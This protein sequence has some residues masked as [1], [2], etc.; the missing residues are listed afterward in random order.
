MEL[1]NS[2]ET[3]YTI[4]LPES[5]ASRCTGIALEMSVIVP[6]T[7]IFYQLKGMIL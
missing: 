7:P 4:T 6:V 1:Y 5:L 3:V 2:I